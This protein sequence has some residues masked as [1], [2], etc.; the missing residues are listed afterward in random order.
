MT[1]GRRFFL[2]GAVALSVVLISAFL[3]IRFTVAGAVTESLE[4]RLA[5]A[6]DPA[7]ELLAVEL[8]GDFEDAA[9]RLSELLGLRVTIVNSE[10]DVLGES[11]V[12]TDAPGMLANHANRPEIQRALA[13]EPSLIARPS[14]TLGRDLIY[15]AAVV[16]LPGGPV[17]LRLATPADPLAGTMQNAL[18]ALALSALLGGLVLLVGAS[19]V[20]DHFRAPLESLA[21]YARQLSGGDFGPRPTP[22]AYPAETRELVGALD[23][24]GEQFEDRF[25]ELE[26]QRDEMQAL[27]DSIA[28]GVV[29]LTEDARVLRMNPAAAEHLD[30]WR[31]QTFAPIGTLVRHPELRDYLEESVIMSLEPR[32]FRLNDKHLL[33]S[34]HPMGDRGAVVTLL[35]VTDLRRAEQV[36]RDFV[37][38]ASH[39]LK[40]PLTAIRGFAETLI[41]DEPPPEI[42]REF[43][44]SIRKNTV[45]LQHLVDD[46]LDL[47]RLESGHWA[48]S[49]EEVD[50]RASAEATW[51]I[52]RNEH[53]GREVSF[54]I[55]GDALALADG[56]ALHQIFQNL[57]ANALRYT[58]NGGSL[59][60]AI[61]PEGPM[62][63][64]SVSDTGSGIPS[65]ALPR[66]FE[67]F[68]RVDAG[69]DRAAGGTGLG[70]AIV[71]HLVQSMGG[72]VSAESRLG[73]GTTIHFTLP[74]VEEDL[75]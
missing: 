70:L 30:I 46:L 18:W 53:A 56:Q 25:R 65:S 67:R 2:F 8:S 47:S 60:I 39:E 15:L 13:G 59:G 63:R 19:Q 16:D 7:A 12:S 45:R 32:E 33:V 22:A 4:D 69:R 55:Q 40:T 26:S 9:P 54:G 5:S 73:H 28:E 49:E 1:L 48:A 38:N 43:L 24:L 44:D 64:V 36:R 71:R 42:K 23:L 62:V 52:L 57:L 61:V 50:I 14:A 29:A 27:I 10:G 31:A 66:I 6:L 11:A 37:A 3:T 21:G 41:D 34:S 68:Y 75:E 58:P 17:V 20:R 51:E 72:E 74:R 35:D